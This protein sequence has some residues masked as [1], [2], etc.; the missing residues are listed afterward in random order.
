MQ[1]TTYSIQLLVHTGEI[2]G[3]ALKELAELK[4]LKYLRLENLPS[5]KDPKAVLAHLQNG[6]PNCEIEYP[7]AE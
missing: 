6:L 7:D 5:V 2:S 3:N 4:N 1:D